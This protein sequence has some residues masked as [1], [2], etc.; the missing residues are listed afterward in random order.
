M[1]ERPEGAEAPAVA[2][3]LYNGHVRCLL[4]PALAL[5]AVLAVA[6]EA[7]VEDKCLGGPC[8]PETLP[9]PTTSSGTGSGGGGGGAA[10][11]AAPDTGE[12]PCDVYAALQAKCASC[13]TDPPQ[14]GAPFPLLT[15]EDAHA[16]YG[17]LKRWEVIGI[18]VKAGYMPL[19]TAPALTPEE[20]QVLLDWVAGCAQPAAAGEGC[21]C[22]DPAACP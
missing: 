22:A 13:H 9:P 12:L 1:V 21:E 20:K 11:V 2:G 19:D 8:G 3:L 15:Y 6:C 7:T 18:A 16:P 10:C 4:L 17:N 14:E 5:V